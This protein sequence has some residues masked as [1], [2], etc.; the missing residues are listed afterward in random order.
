ME[1]D[2][3]SMPFCEFVEQTRMI[4]LSAGSS[5]EL[6]D[7]LVYGSDSNYIASVI[8]EILEMASFATRSWRNH[9]SVF[10]T[11]HEMYEYKY[12]HYKDRFLAFTAQY[13]N[14]VRSVYEILKECSYGIRVVMTYRKIMFSFDIIGTLNSVNDLKN[15]LILVANSVTY[16]DKKWEEICDKGAGSFACKPY[17]YSNNSNINFIDAV[18]V[19]ILSNDYTYNRVDFCKEINNI[20]KYIENNTKSLLVEELERLKDRKTRDFGV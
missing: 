20:V 18:N 16:E 10:S 17:K 14:D 2:M 7:W 3:C 1:F 15:S 11:I 4:G 6:L 12:E 13:E 5:V 8:K 19:V 9:I